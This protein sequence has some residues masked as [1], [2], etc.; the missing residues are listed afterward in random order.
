[1]VDENDTIAAIATASGRGGIGIIRVS[2][3]NTQFICEEIV[4]QALT[5]R[6]AYLKSFKNSDQSVLDSGLVIFFKGPASYT[7]EDTLELQGHG[8]PVILDMVLKRVLNLGARLARAGEFTERAFLNNKLDL[9]QAEAVADVIDAGTEQA[10]RS[11]QRSLQGEFSKQIEALQ[12]K[13]TNIRLYVESA[14]DFSDEDIDFL[15]SDELALK[16]SSTKQQFEHIQKVAKQGSL[17]REGMSIVL[18][19]SPNAGKSSLLNALTQKDTAIVTEIAGT[20]RDTLKE[21]IQIDGMPLHII[22][23]AGL[24]DTD[25][26]VEKEGVKRAHSAIQ[27]A[28]R[29]LLVIDDRERD[30]YS[31]TERLKSIPAS[32]PVSIVYNKIDLTATPAGL[33]L[34]G[35]EPVINVSMKT[36]EGLSDLRQHLKE[37]MGFHTGEQGVFMARRRHL[38]ALKTSEQLYLT[39]VQQ[40]SEHQAGE[41]FAEDMR[42]AQRALS[43]ITG[44][45]T[46]DDL[47]GEIFSSFCIG[48]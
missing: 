7:G 14:I 37:C 35:K 17:L 23:T 6:Q 8:G 38:D 3:P 39:G 16:L 13:I 2:G 40:F 18:A 25:D 36:T 47:L 4:G 45:L 11:A 15:G 27:K 48:K 1:M 28:D 19:G 29:V 20:T 26:I 32:I 33:S 21:H 9:A 42:Q 5:P 30:D 24:R 22:D 34:V 43:E 12:Q 44:A 41:L 46:A 31:Y 10:V